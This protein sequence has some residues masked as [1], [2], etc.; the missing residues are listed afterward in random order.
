MGWIG[1]M[2]EWD[3]LVGWAGGMDGWGGYM[4]KSEQRK[5][6]RI[7]CSSTMTLDCY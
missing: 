6:Q 7:K 2:D 1:G 3:G 4:R 5:L